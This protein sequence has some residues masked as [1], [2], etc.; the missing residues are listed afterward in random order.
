MLGPTHSREQLRVRHDLPPRRGREAKAPG[1]LLRRQ[2]LLGCD[3]L[4]RPK[5]ALDGGQDVAGRGHP[6]RC[7][8]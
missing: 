3:H 6:P 2:A 4:E 8:S 1:D 5:A 7:G